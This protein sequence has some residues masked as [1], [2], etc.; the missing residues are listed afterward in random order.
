MA[1]KPLVAYNNQETRD[2]LKELHEHNK[3]W[4]EHYYRKP[5]IFELIRP[6]RYYK[7]WARHIRYTRMK[8]EFHS[9]MYKQLMDEIRKNLAEQCKIV[10]DL[11]ETLKPKKP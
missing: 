10:A 3:A 2:L 9:W 4:D 6:W 11:Q 7:Q 5:G 8:Q 1:S